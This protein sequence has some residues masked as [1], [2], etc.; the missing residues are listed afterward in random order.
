MLRNL[1]NI[2]CVYAFI[3]LFATLA[4]L[5]LGIWLLSWITWCFSSYYVTREVAFIASQKVIL[6]GAY[7]HMVAIL[8]VLCLSYHLCCISF[9]I[10]RVRE[11]RGI[12]DNF[13]KVKNSISLE[14]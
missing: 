8:L 5:V 13:S 2:A 6:W 11:D 7:V 4:T 10:L 12:F 3:G 9:R 14:L 1:L